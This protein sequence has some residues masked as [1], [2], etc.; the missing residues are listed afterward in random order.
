[1]TIYTS[2]GGVRD[3][4]SY[5]SPNGKLVGTKTT[6]DSLFSDDFGGSAVDTTK[7]DVID[8][9]LD[10]NQDL[11]YGT[12]TQGAIGTLTTGITDAVANSQ[13][14][15]SMG[16]TLNA[17]RW[18]LSK[19]VF[20]GKEDIM[21]VLSRSQA[22]TANS[23]FIGLC[24]VDPVTFVPLLNLNLAGEFT[25]RGGCEFAQTTTTTAYQAEAI[26]DS[27]PAKATGTVGVATALTTTQEFLMEIDSR[28]ITVSSGTVNSVAAKAAGASRVSTQCPNDQKLYKLIMRFKNVGTPATDTDIVIQRILVVDNYE[29][30]VQISTAEGDSI[31]V[32]ALAV[33]VLNTPTFTPTPSANF[34]A[35]STHHLISAAN[36]NATSIKTTAANV[37]EAIFSNNG[38]SVAYVKIY[39][40]AS[41][42]TVG[43]D[44]PVATV[45]VPSN[46]TVGMAF[47]NFGLRLT[48]GLAIAITGGMAVSDTTAV[49]AAQVSSHFSYT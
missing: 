11:G 4:S 9:G 41:A 35:G 22:I 29:Q 5:L 40:K 31:A 18:Y 27:S 46:G 39:N 42:P 33:N 7:W 16:T 8:G 15:V 26:G 24:E 25:N 47:G 6:L 3:Q 44:T 2:G 20:A 21:V 43:T 13:L 10:A 49:A 17:E 28:D 12:L 45:L 32:K 14:T 38:A 34:G 36:T 30:R 48:A 37:N 19:Q 23:V 1:M